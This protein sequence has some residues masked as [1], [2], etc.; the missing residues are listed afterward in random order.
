MVKEVL[1]ILIYSVMFIISVINL[2]G[3]E[4]SLNTSISAMC[5]LLF[6]ISIMMTLIN[7]KEIL[8][9]G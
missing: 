9:D 4:S 3:S 6:M 8:S 7:I 2:N 1:K 5:M